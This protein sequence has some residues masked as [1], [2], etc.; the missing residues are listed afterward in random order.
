MDSITVAYYCVAHVFLCCYFYM[1]DV[2]CR[3]LILVTFVLLDEYS[4]L[5][6]ERMEVEKLKVREV[7]SDGSG[8]TCI[9]I[10]P[11]LHLARLILDSLTS[12]PL[13]ILN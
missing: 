4:S 2:P 13:L 1:F 11:L 3:N 7:V 10:F 8:T 6:G 5:R 9:C 12:T